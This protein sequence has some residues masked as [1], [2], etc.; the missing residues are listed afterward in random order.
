VHPWLA[1][2]VPA[3]VVLHVLASF[4]FVLLHAPSMTAMLVLRRERR[5]ERVQAMLEMSG[6]ASAYSWAGLTALGLTGL[7]LAA[8]QHTWRAPWVWGSMLVLFLVTFTMSPMAARAFN[9]ARHAAGLPYFDGR[10]RTQAG[11][12]DPEALERALD[13]IRRRAPAVLAIGLLGLALLVWLMV[14]RPA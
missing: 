6:S 11:A 5:L 14:A 2:H 9:E 7:A 13:V 8:A 4:G 3:L 10:G 12:A 1:P